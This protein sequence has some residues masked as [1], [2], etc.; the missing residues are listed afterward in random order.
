MESK[1]KNMFSSIYHSLNK[2]V[3]L[4]NRKAA[5]ILLTGELEIIKCEK[6]RKK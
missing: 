3:F 6:D 2:T 1:K 4:S 5:G